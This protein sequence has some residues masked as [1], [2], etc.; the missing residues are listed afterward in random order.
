MTTLATRSHAV[1]VP[2]YSETWPREPRSAS[3]ARSLVRAALDAWALDHL[4]EP[5]ALIA[6]ELVSNSVAHTRCR[7][8]RL[9][10]TLPSSEAV[11]IAVADASR[12]VPEK[13]KC[14]PMATVG[15]GLHLVSFL[16][17]DWGVDLHAKSKTVWAELLRREPDAGLGSEAG[18]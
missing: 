2:G 18:S 11:R 6:S 7:F 8:V 10:I 17:N 13:R 15:R 4:I 1:G 14:P 9:S 5:G 16:S 12:R 3:R